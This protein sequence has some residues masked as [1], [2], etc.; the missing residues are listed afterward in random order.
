VSTPA[1]QFPDG[2]A[3]RGSA[4][5]LALGREQG[6]PL[7]E[8][9]LEAC[10]TA[11]R[12]DELDR[13]IAGRGVLNLMQF[14]LD[15]DLLEGDERTVEVTVK[16]SGVLGEVRQQAAAFAGLLDRLVPKSMGAAAGGAPAAEGASPL[17]QVLALV[18]PGAESSGRP[19]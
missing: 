1:S 11:D 13:V 16:I 3:E 12:L 10:R 15:L 4:L 8:V 17:A 5:W 9:A 18:Q 19:S 14:R 7:G 6:T 2:L